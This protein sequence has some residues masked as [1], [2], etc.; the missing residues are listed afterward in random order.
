MSQTKTQITQN[1]KI[2]DQKSDYI[3]ILL[4]MNV[5]CLFPLSGVLVFYQTA[6]GVGVIVDFRKAG[7]YDFFGP[8]DT[9]SYDFTTF[10]RS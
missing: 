1:D 3:D 4:K 10:L 2:K 5:F 7:F 6:V 9:I 8:H